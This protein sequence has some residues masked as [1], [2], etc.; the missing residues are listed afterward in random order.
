MCVNICTW[1]GNSHV[2]CRAGIRALLVKRAHDWGADVD[3]TTESMNIPKGKKEF[4]WLISSSI[5][6]TLYSADT[7]VY[8]I[9]DYTLNEP[10]VGKSLLI[11]TW[12]ISL[13]QDDES[14]FLKKQK[15]TSWMPFEWIGLNIS[16]R[17]VMRFIK[18]TCNNTD[19]TST[20][21]SSP[22]NTKVV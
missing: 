15:H 22:T 20:N 13:F 17:F 4:L 19:L 11:K 18:C 1:P 3:A 2:T 10:N 21:Y 12:K 5:I 16:N 6:A 14:A 7:I 8:I 9:Y